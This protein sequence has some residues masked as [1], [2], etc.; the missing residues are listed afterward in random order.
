M[1]ALLLNQQEQET[2]DNMLK[3]IDVLKR[4]AELDASNPRVENKMTT[5][6]GLVTVSNIEGSA[7]LNENIPGMME[8]G[9]S[10]SHTPASL[11]VSAASGEELS[12]MLR[13]LMSLA[14]VKPVEPSAP[15]NGHQE[16]EIGAT[17]PV[18]PIGGNMSDMI[19]MV[20]K[21]NDGDADN[22]TGNEPDTFDD[23]EGETE[24]QNDRMYDN[25]PDEEVEPH[26]YGDELTT[27]KQQGFSQR[28]GDNPYK[29]T[30]ESQVTHLASQLLS[31]WK[32]FVSESKPSAGLSKK[33]KSETVKKAKAGK[34]IGKPGKN[35]EKVAAKAAKATGSKKSGEKIAAAAMW[36]N[37]KK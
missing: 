3:M 1:S 12:G 32:Q 4:L 16:I 9:N 17:H 33:K 24:S 30:H 5:E 2:E 13:N 35:F 28:K 20:D 6:Q 31:D 10:A 8:V 36:K 22:S 27:P 25:S 7:R 34:D 37:I 14:G 26:E 19:S 11:S 23:E 29:P 15:M 21:M 18:E